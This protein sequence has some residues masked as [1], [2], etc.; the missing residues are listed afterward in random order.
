[1]IF[2]EE[3]TPN[4]LQPNRSDSV[5][6]STLFPLID[7]DPV[8]LGF[9]S[10]TSVTE[11]NS[12]LSL[13]SLP[14]LQPQ[15]VGDSNSIQSLSPIGNS[16]SGS[17]QEMAPVNSGSISLSTPDSPSPS[18]LSD[19]SV[20]Q[21]AAVLA[22]SPD[23]LN[24]VVRTRS[25]ADLYSNSTPVQQSR[26]HSDLESSSSALASSSVK[27]SMPSQGFIKLPDEPKT[28]A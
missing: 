17:I 10:R 6:Y 19:D 22:T 12:D 15:T 23:S 16:N 2:D 4:L 24:N 20:H 14:P 25:L 18:T 27:P 28:I 7:S 13:P 26:I 8:A 1:V 11:S 5:S 3:T 21:S 9:P